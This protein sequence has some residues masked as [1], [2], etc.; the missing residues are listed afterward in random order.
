MLPCALGLS[1]AVTGEASC[2][3]PPAQSRYECQGCSCSALHVTALAACS[4]AL[5]MPLC[6]MQHP[7]GCPAP[8]S[9][10][11]LSQW[12]P[13]ATREHV[14]VCWLKQ[15]GASPCCTLGERS[16]WHSR[17]CQLLFCQS[18]ACARLLL[19]VLSCLSTVLLTT[20][21]LDLRGSGLKVTASRAACLVPAR[22][23]RQG[24]PVPVMVTGCLA[25][26]LGPPT[27]CRTAGSASWLQSHRTVPLSRPQCK[28]AECPASNLRGGHQRCSTSDVRR[29]CAPS[30]SEALQ[31]DS[32]GRTRPPCLARR[33]SGHP[34]QPRPLHWRP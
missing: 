34:R 21:V 12:G 2:S 4:A 18:A 28:Q 3:R 5:V 13:A 6:S 24:P 8:W 25:Q 33:L 26:C 15:S 30:P 14:K 17:D 1:V 16:A 7:A 31:P 32:K 11:W 22:Q 19:L 23:E 9:S 29:C 27:P 10:A 20:Q